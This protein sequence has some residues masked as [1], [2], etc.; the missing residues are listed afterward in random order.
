MVMKI[1]H[2]MPMNQDNHAQYSFV[3]KL[4]LKILKFN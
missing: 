1:H 2:L 3:H 4:L